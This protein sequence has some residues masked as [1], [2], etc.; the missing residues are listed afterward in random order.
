LNGEC[1]SRY[2]VTLPGEVPSAPLLKPAD[3]VLVPFTADDA[4]GHRVCPMSWGQKEIWQAMI[5]QRNWLPMGGTKPLPAGTTLQDVAEE[6]R[7]LVSRFPSMRT[8]LH[9]EG[10]AWPLQELFDSGEIALEVF[11]ADAAGPAETA[12]AVEAQYR[13]TDYNFAE[14]WPV[15][16]AVVR[17]DGEPAYMVAIMCHLVGD[18]VG[19]EFMLRDVAVLSTEP[20]TGLQQ[21]DQ[22]EWQASPAGLRQSAGALR[23]WEKILRTIPPRPLPDSAD[24]RSPRH[25]RAEYDSPALRRVLPVLAERTGASASSVLLAMYSVALAR[26]TGINP[27]VSR[28]IVSNRFRPGLATPVCQIAQGGICA[29]DVAGLTFDEAV[30]RAQRDTITMFKY[31]Y[32]DPEQ[33]TALFQQ[34]SQERGPDLNI[35]CFVNDRRGPDLRSPNAAN[36]ESGAI[37]A[38]QPAE[39]G[40][41][42]ESVFRWLPARDIPVERLFIHFDDT[43]IG[44]MI[45]V[46]ADTHFLS[47]AHMEALARGMEA[48]VLEAEYDPAA[49]TRVE[50]AAAHV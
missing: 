23:Y 7:Y 17:Q 26:I 46:C 37:A 15:R 40:E 20:Q 12:S 10:D 30:D 42:T 5:N 35:S 8:R 38:G 47:P 13:N 4:A 34:V 6:L 25:W 41:P 14:D 50:T 21:V 48:V 36:A 39:D 43:A 19:V 44:I 32:F 28:T 49:P 29:L 27:V 33:V 18:G 31:A 11:D 3:R 2:P 16:M 9:Y 1:E 24:P 45:T 22:A